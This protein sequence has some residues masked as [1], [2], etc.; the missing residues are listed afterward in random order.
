MAINYS[1]GYKKQRAITR[2]NRKKLFQA[3]RVWV[4]KNSR[5][6]FVYLM[7]LASSMMLTE[8][9]LGRN[10]AEKFMTLS[11]VMPRKTAQI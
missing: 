2:L 5:K 6:N 9:M 1:V 11:P 8:R 3:L 10:A 4:A 7:K